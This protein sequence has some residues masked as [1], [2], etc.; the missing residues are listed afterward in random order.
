MYRTRSSP[1]QNIKPADTAASRRHSNAH[2]QPLPRSCAPLHLSGGVSHKP[3]YI[4]YLFVSF[5]VGR[6]SHDD[7]AKLNR[8]RRRSVTGGI[9]G[10]GEGKGSGRRET[11]VDESSKETADRVAKWQTECVGSTFRCYSYHKLLRLPRKVLL[12]CFGFPAISFG[13]L[14]HLFQRVSFVFLSAVCQRICTASIGMYV[15]SYLP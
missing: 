11:A 15:V 10:N 4:Y 5:S 3:L 13:S 12:S 8:V 7:E 6:V 1:S 2:R 14:L 9:Q